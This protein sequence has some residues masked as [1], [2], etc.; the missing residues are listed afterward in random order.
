MGYT[1]YA[2]SIVIF[3]R[4]VSH[5]VQRFGGLSFYGA[6]ISKLFFAL[7]FPAKITYSKTGNERLRQ[8]I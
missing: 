7:C 1:F 3:E 6:T 2:V 8:S 4:G 5:L